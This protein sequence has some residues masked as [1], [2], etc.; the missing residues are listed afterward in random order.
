MK[1]ER[2]AVVRRVL[3]AVEKDPTTV[4]AVLLAL[5]RECKG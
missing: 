2:K 1:K 4:A 3:Q 5:R